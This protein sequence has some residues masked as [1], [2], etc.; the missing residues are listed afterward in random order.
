MSASGWF[1]LPGCS[2]LRKTEKA[3]EIM[4]ENGVKHWLPFSQLHP[5]MLRDEQ[6]K[7]LFGE[8]PSEKLEVGQTDRT[9]VMTS[10]LAKQKGFI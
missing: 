4:D 8:L 2:V 5:D 9:V 3:F 1:H 7:G 10:W 6:T